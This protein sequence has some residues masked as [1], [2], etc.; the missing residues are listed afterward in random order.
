MGISRRDVL[1]GTASTTCL[2]GM[3]F[4]AQAAQTRVIGGAAFGT[5]WRVT[6]PNGQNIRP[7]KAAIGEIIAIIDSALSPFRPDSEISRFNQSATT[8]WMTLSKDTTRVVQEG[9]RIATLTGGAF[10]P[11]VGP[12]VG[13]F[14]FGPITGHRVGTHGNIAARGTEVRKDHPAL[15]FDPCGIAKGFALDRMVGQLDDLGLDAYLAELGGEVFARGIHPSGRP[16]RVG[17]ERPG[18]G[19]LTFQRILHLNGEALATSGDSVNGY[20]VAGRRYSHIID[21][22]K[23]LPVDNDIAAVSV[24]APLAITADALATALMAM[25][26]RQGLAVA[27]REKLPVL[28]LLRGR[29]GLREITSTPFNA[30]VSV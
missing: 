29:D 11:T 7:I 6:L 12:I 14:G 21:P 13:R 10:D 24:I 17:I 19:A 15:T 9:L 27:E 28:Y 4:I 16:W 26:P 25:G 8:Q 1:I 5:Y 18:P 2:L 3:S 22:R 20:V 30:Y 23:D